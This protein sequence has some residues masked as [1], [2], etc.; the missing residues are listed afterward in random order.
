MNSD[1]IKTIT[2][3]IG[4]KGT[5]AQARWRV[6]DEDIGVR[7]TYT[8]GREAIWTIP[9]YAES[10]SDWTFGEGNPLIETGNRFSL[11]LRWAARILPPYQLW[12]S[13]LRR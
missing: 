2:T 3:L 4:I 9:S 6:D 13:C 10:P 7:L 8:S 11:S 5:L 1:I 12:H